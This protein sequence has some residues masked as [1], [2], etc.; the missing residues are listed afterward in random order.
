M[1]AQAPIA[2][3]QQE[4][5]IPH[6]GLGLRVAFRFCFVYFGLF[7]I[8]TQIFGGL[9]SIPKMEILDPSS[10]WP[11]RQITFWTAA[12]IFHA[13]LPLVYTG[14]GS[15]DKTF[16][17]VL[18]FCLLVFAALATAIWSVLDRRRENYVTLYKW[19]RLFIRFA[20]AG[21]MFGYGMD[22]LIPL[23]MPFP[24]LTRLLE[25]FGNFSP[26]GVLWSS[27]GASPAYEIFTGF[28]EML[29]GI[30]LIAPRTTM[31]GALVCVADTTQVFMLNM[32]YDVPVKLFSFHLVLM[33]L[34]LV[35]PE[36]QRLADFFFRNRTVAPSAQPQLF[37][38]RR[39]NRI[40]IAAQIV[41]GIWMVGT[42]AYG[43][44]GDWHTYGGGRPKSPLYGI[45]S[46]D[47]LSIDGQIRSP[48][49]TD[50][51][52]WHRAIFDFPEAVAFQRMD[53]S[54]ARYGASINVNDK[55]L[56][57]TKVSDKNWKA[58]FT[59]QRV[60]QD[61]LI[62]DGNMD[63]HNIHMRLQLAD[64]GKFLLVSRGFHWIQEYPFNR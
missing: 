26:M 18:A 46:V 49:L 41:F 38:T 45:W 17:W 2:P 16:D 39:A 22:K 25:P 61:Q 13:R 30:L 28:A 40:A 43:G 11:M 53:D 36:F 21:Q 37:Q 32:T 63:S 8:C 7:C 51:D 23:Q 15:G 56:A 1:G 3:L 12:H 52:R 55:T 31:L 47:E 57:L 54:L 60:A 58:N 24:Y 42:A 35:A 64:R 62:L 5:Q 34:F 19:F 29:G 44:W 33:A 27:V 9:I 20:L 14:S 50:Y 6:W 59:F 10:L 48:L 4:P